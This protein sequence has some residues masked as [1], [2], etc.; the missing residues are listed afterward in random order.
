MKPSFEVTYEWIESTIR[1]HRERLRAEGFDAVVGI[2]R[3]GTV[4]AF[5]AAQ[6]VDRSLSFLR[7]DRP[8]GQVF[9]HSIAPTSRQKILLV[10]DIAGEGFTL[11]RG[12]AFLEKEGHEVKTLTI[13]FDERSRLRPDFSTDL[14]HQIIVLPW[15]R[16]RLHPEFIADLGQGV[17]QP[18][19]HYQLIALDLD[20]LLL[21]DIEPAE[22]EKD[23]AATLLRRD[24]LLPFEK[25]HL[26]A[27]EPKRTVIITGRPEQDR[28]RT[29]RW[30]GQ[31]GYADLPLHMREDSRFPHTDSA[32]WKAS[33]ARHLGVTHFYES[34][35]WQATLITEH[36][37]LLDVFYWN[38][39]RKLRYQIGRAR[40]LG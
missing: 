38:N 7:Y 32:L 9:W 3:G 17:I 22:Y 27:F 1:G 2:L 24:G 15:E 13:A 31:H 28:E 30:L 14:S 19:H 18:D 12:K 23:L 20:G 29:L 11:V 35:L 6:I 4:P 33:Q 5:I 25:G 26:P 34:D 16:H 40:R 21:P 36:C 10:D 39:D 37:P 8:S